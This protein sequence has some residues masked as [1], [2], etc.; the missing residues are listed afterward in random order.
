M[1]HKQP[2]ENSDK[3]YN[4]E[5]HIEH[6]IKQLQ[7]ISHTMFVIRNILEQL[8]DNI[9]VSERTIDDIIFDLEKLIVGD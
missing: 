6:H 8:V 1:T 7:E 9:N 5:H 2:Q 3:L 4:I